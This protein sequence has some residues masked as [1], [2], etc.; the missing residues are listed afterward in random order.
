MNREKKHIIL[1]VSNDLVSDQ[2]VHKVATSLLNNGYTVCVVG[3]KL[4]NSLPLPE[5][6]YATKRLRLLFT[7]NMMFYAELNIRLFIYLLFSNY[8][9]ATANDLDT[10]LG[11]YCATRIRR[12]KLVYDSHEYF[13]EVPELVHNTKAKRVW[14]TIESW[15]FPK[16]THCMTVCES[17][18]HIY[19]QKYSVPVIVVRNVPLLQ[20]HTM[21]TNVQLPTIPQPHIILYQ[22]AV[23][24]GRGIELMIQAMEYINNT[25]LL[26][27][28]SGD[29]LEELKEFAKQSKTA[30]SIYFTGRIPFQQLPAYTNIATIGIS[31][32]EDIGLNYKYALP[33]KIFDY[34]HAHKPIVVSDLPE[35][36]SI[37]QTYNCGE[38]IYNRNPQAI[39]QQIT[40]ILSN[41]DLL[42][43][44]AQNSAIASKELCWE[45]EEQKLLQCYNI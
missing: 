22:G 18:A 7:K 29:K 4:P 41:T 8:A 35:M 6:P 27:I 21:S 38:I 9:I 36:S 44:Y 42:Q 33:N 43:L 37:I 3:R 11:M 28:G 20:K 34:I 24:V 12:K 45:R 5:L 39:G 1:A 30:S 17:I 19:E 2:R 16:L 40:K 13:T 23:N 25:A 15:I 32:E 14:E 31:L 10:L 26:I